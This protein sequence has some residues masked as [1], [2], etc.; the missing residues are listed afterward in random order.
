MTSEDAQKLV[1][2]GM[3]RLMHDP[4]EWAQWAHTFSRFTKYSPG[5]V[6]LIM[7]Q[8]PDASYVAGYHAWR[9]R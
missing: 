5:N 2:A 8:R 3:D 7:S 9:G 1:D 4:T 6:L